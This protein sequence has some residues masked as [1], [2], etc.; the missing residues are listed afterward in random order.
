MHMCKKRKYIYV[1]EQDDMYRYYS[2]CSLSV[3]E[4]TFVESAHGN[5]T[6]RQECAS[7]CPTHCSVPLRIALHARLVSIL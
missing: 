3:K 6:E 5:F 2:R 1:K 7:V 4:F